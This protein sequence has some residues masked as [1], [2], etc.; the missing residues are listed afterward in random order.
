MSANN[1]ARPRF[2]QSY[3][4]YIHLA[5]W[6]ALF[7][8]PFFYC[9][10]EPWLLKFARHTCA[11]LFGLMIT[12]YCNLLWAIDKLLY[13]KRY[14]LFVLFNV[15]LFFLVDELR[16]WVVDML[17]FDP[18]PDPGAKKHKP[19]PGAHS[20]FIYNELIFTALAIFTSLG[21]RH[22]KEVSRLKLAREK[23]ENETLSSELSLLRYQ[24]QPHFFFNSLNNIYSLIGSSPS[25][26][27][28]AVH[29][30]SKMM[31]FVLYDCRSSLV[32]LD[33]EVTFIKNYISLMRLRIRAGSE[34]T[35]NAPECLSGVTVPPLLFIP[36][37]ENA[38]KH[39]VSSDGTVRIACDLRIEGGRILFEVTNVACP[40]EP[41]EDKSHSGIGLA[42]LAKLLDIIYPND[43]TFTARADDDGMFCANISIPLTIPESSL[44]ITNNSND[45]H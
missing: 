1:V 18:A 22:S 25:D 28:K 40:C 9:I 30:L 27:Q 43:H 5:I 38:F 20:L 35:F 14:L 26:A 31:R 41:K 11:M 23:M 19:S 44:D 21:V 16:D 10:E 33:N 42:N 6:V 8:I 12:F 7:A 3:E 17:S 24:V 32:S 36:L 4:I 34:V 15:V 13:K 37:V 2:A 39:G 45:R 29:S